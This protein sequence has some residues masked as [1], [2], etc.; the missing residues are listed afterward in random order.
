MA[1][2]LT[3]LCGSP[4]LVTLV[5][6]HH[7]RDVHVVGERALRVVVEAAVKDQQDPLR[8]VRAGRVREDPF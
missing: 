4:A 1:H 6:R 7:E 5:V 3:Q 2:A 8:R